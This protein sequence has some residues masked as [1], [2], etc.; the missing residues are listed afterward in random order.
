MRLQNSLDLPHL[1]FPMVPSCNGLI[2]WDVLTDF[3]KVR[4][5][6]G[7]TQTGSIP[8]AGLCGPES[9]LGSNDSHKKLSS[10]VGKPMDQI[11]IRASS[12]GA[13]TLPWTSVVGW[14]VCYNQNSMLWFLALLRTSVAVPHDPNIWYYEICIVS[15]H[16][17]HTIAFVCPIA[18][19]EM[20]A[21]MGISATLEN[22]ITDVSGG[23]LKP[24]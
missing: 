10:F 4:P 13:R 17:S 9:Y 21:G 23:V 20:D 11:G 2:A 14:M 6:F 8:T 18:G 3:W 19:D 16:H 5:G 12:K 24:H 22:A 1:D 7:V 15:T